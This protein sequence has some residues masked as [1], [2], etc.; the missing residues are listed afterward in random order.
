MGAENLAKVNRVL[1]E[2]DLVIWKAVSK[3]GVLPSVKSYEEYTNAVAIG[4]EAAAEAQRRVAEG[5]MNEIERSR[6]FGMSQ[7]AGNLNAEVQR[8]IASAKEGN[9]EEPVVGVL[10]RREGTRL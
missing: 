4:M 9:G 3:K 1:S 6:N 8:W 10:D 2:S 7:N 5:T